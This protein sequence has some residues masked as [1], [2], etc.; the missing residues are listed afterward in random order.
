MLGAV[1]VGRPAQ[2]QSITD[3]PTY[4]AGNPTPVLPA[5]LSKPP[6][7]RPAPPPDDGLGDHGFY[8]EADTLIRDDP[9]NMWTAQ[10]GVEARYQGRVARADTMVYDMRAGVVTADG[11]VQ[12]ISEDGSVAFATHMVLDDKMRAGFAAG[13]ASRAN[14]PINSVLGNTTANLKFAADIAVRRSEEVEELDRAIFTPCD[15]CAKSGA[16]ITP[17]WS[18][19]ASKIIEDQQKHVIYYRNAVFRVKGLPLFY[20]PVFWH[21]D[22]DAPRASGLLVPNV[23]VGQKLGFSYEQPALL[24]ISPSAELTVDPMFNS[25]VNPFLNLEWRERFYSGEIDA[26]MGYTDERD[27]DGNGNKFGDLTSRSFILANGQFNLTPD[28]TFG[29]TAERASDP[30]IFIKYNI[31]NPY[32]QYGLFL[33][34]SQR[35]LSQAYV[36]RQDDN[37]YLSIAAIDV[38]GLRTTDNNA[39][40][41]LV[42]PLIEGRWDAPFDVF[43]GSLRLIGSGVLLERDESPVDPSQPGVDSRRASAELDWQRTFTLDNGMRLQPFANVRG[44]IYDVS[45][46]SSTDRSPKTISEGLETAGV[47][48]SWPF[49]KQDGGTTVVLEPIAQLALSPDIK[50]NAEIPNEDS[51][52]FEYDETDLFSPNKFTGY[53][54]FDSGQRLNVGGQATVDWGDG[55]SAQVLVG[56]TLRA[57][58]TDVFPPN[59]GLNSQAA[60]WIVAGNTTPIDGLSLFER[61]VFDDAFDLDHLELGANWATDRAS[62]YVRYLTDNTQITGPVKDFEASGEFFA[63][64]NWGV[65]LTGVRDLVLNDWRLEELGLVYKD[66]CIR[67]QVVYRHENTQVGALGESDSVFL[68][69]TLATLGNQGYNN[70]D[71]R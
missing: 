62:G 5:E 23:S 24:V 59:T 42:A 1:C 51:V 22:P 14:M 46:I 12:L 34:D 26:R 69:L 38:Q 67:V 4:V 2:A 28:W 8:L 9:H 7:P 71:F 15:I 63:T 16:S 27:F 3:L 6:K 33:S 70:G 49:I 53:D 25:K 54:L 20:A 18:I 45:D 68:R 13:F 21:P 10:G 43:G 39:T 36:T 31:S 65:S 44:D 37:S 17:T 47:T 32:P 41:P 11:H 57:Q 64:N 55:L 56:R 58:T 50:P 35:L 40:F 29:F 52:V 30:L 60:D 48:W 19:S 66:D 61:A